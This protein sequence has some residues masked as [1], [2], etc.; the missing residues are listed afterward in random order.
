M[1]TMDGYTSETQAWLDRRF[2]ATDEQGVYIGHQPI[3][4]FRGGPSEVG[5]VERYAITYQ[6]MRALSRLNFSTLIDIGGAE[7]YK[8]ALVRQL[9]GAQVRSADLSAEACLRAKELFNVDGE[10]I[11]IHAL[12]Y[13]DS[14][15][16]VV[17]CSETLEHVVDYRSATRELMRVAR[18]AVVITVP[19]EPEEVVRQNIADNIPHAHI[20]A[21]DTR[22]FDFVKE[23]GWQVVCRRLGSKT[24]KVPRE[25][26]EAR[27][28]GYEQERFPHFIYDA[29]NR[30]VPILKRLCGRWSV[31]AT[32]TVDDWLSN[33]TKTY[34]GMC[35]VL[36]R[37][38]V[39]FSNSPLRCV[40][41]S[42][43]LNFSVPHYRLPPES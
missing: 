25:L 7:G 28:R 11:D 1:S 2:R 41:V 29:Y 24:M 17:L 26:I 8:A 27:P 14:S 16:D 23:E 31:R 13:Q 36:L 34:Q 9:F 12:P 10:V 35:F 15:H 32:V 19:R 22:S 21:L 5:L 43:V 38:G 4:G 39:E 6:I 20:H 33:S 18:K 37:E 42:D 30:A 40:T 3:Y